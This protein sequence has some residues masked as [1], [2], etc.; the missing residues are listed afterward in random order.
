MKAYQNYL[1]LSNAHDLTALDFQN[2]GLFARTWC[3]GRQQAKEPKMKLPLIAASLVTVG[4][5]TGSGFAATTSDTSTIKMIDVKAHH[6]TLADGKMFQLPSK[7]TLHAYK[8]GEKVRVFY[9]DHMGSMTVT[10][11]H[12]A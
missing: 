3:P 5:L 9:N 1:S 6:L 12:K 4:L 7:W 10:R 2:A 11:I 8:A